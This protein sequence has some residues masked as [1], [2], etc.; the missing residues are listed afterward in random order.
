AGAFQHAA[1]SAVARASLQ[2]LSGELHAASAAMLFDVVDATADALSGR[3]EDLLSGRSM[4]GSWVGDLGWQGDLRRG[5]YAGATF[6]NAGRM[7]GSDFRIGRN[8]AFGYAV[9]QSRGAGQLD[10]SWDHNRISTDSY[11]L[12]GGLANG[13]W[14]AEGQIGGGRFRQ[15]MQRLLLLGG[16]T[17]PVGS[18]LVGNYANASIETGYRLNMGDAQVTPFLQLGYQHLGQGGFAEQDGYGFGLAAAP[19]GTGRLQDAFGLRASRDWSL[20]HGLRMGLDATASWRHALRQYGEAFDATFTG[21][22]DWLP[23]DGVGLSRDYSTLAVGLEIWPSH[24]FGLRL[25][26]QR[27]QADRQRSDDFALQGSVSF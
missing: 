9:G 6:Q 23:M 8:A 15:D 17:A 24:D 27:E 12:Y 21:F 11:A 22:D 13:A 3:F 4:A 10:Q 14:Y 16:I 19:H 18:D 2:S 7:V 1:T 5:G 20:A 25:G 26:Y